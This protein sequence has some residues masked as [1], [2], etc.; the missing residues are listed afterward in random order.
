MVSAE[1]EHQALVDRVKFQQRSSD[2][3]R[4]GWR[5]YCGALAD[6]VRDPQKHSSEFLL[7]FLE[8]LE[9]GQVP[10]AQEDY[11][12]RQIRSACPS[13]GGRQLELWMPESEVSV[14]K[15]VVNSNCYSL[16]PGKSSLLLPG[17]LLLDVGAHVGT[18]AALALR[19][20]RV[21]V[22]ALEPHP[23]TFQILQRNLADHPQA[24]LL[25]LAI[26]GGPSGSRVPLYAHRGTNNPSRL[27]FASLFTTRSHADDAIL[28]SSVTLQDLIQRYAPTVVKLDAE[29]AERFLRDVEDFGQI[30]RLVV[31]WD[32]THN[33]YRRNWEEVRQHLELHDFKVSLRGTMPAFHETTGEALLKD[34]RGKKRGNTGMIFVASRKAMAAIAGY[35]LRDV[36]IPEEPESYLGS[37]N[38]QPRLEE[39][40]LALSME[41]LEERLRHFGEP[42]REVR[43]EEY[44][45]LGFKERRTAELVKSLCEVYQRPTFRRSIEHSDGV[46]LQEDGVQKLLEVLRSIN[47]EENLRPSVNAAGYLILKLVAIPQLRLSWGKDEGRRA[48]LWQLALEL[49]KAASAKAA[50]FEVTAMAV[51]KNF[52]GSPHIDQNDFSVQYALAVGDFASGGE[53][54]VEENPFL[55]RGLNT[56]N[57]LVCIDGRFPHWVSGYTGE[58]YSI[59]F[60]RTSGDWDPPQQ[61][62][63]PV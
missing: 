26:D 44:F 27:F 40:L 8:L 1:S 22:V 47:F 18:A 43:G 54:C 55:V 13:L 2:I 9:T 24:T 6:G 25:N 21:Q 41:Q 50:A 20:P 63:H 37:E 52:R 23:V 53:L 62:V 42:V 33:K 11:E 32:W 31:E 7:K 38:A 45:L 46:P 61:A 49:L 19:T 4:E 34:P 57:R 17:D 14:M 30:R 10:Q 28:V 35:D 39:Q 3:A 12:T 59:I 58:R 48:R 36:A 29:G 15:D 56:H 16:A 5:H 51:T 60:Y